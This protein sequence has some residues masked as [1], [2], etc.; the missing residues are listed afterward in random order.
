[1]LNAIIQFIRNFLCCI[2]DTSYGEAKN[3]V[4]SWL[5]DASLTNHWILALFQIKLVE[6]LHLTTPLE[7]L[8]SITQFYVVCTG[9]P[10]AINSYIQSYKQMNRIYRLIQSRQTAV[11][12]THGERLVHA[13]LI[14]E[15][16]MSIRSMIVA[17]NCFF[18]SASFVWLSANSWHIT[19]TDWIG[20][21]PALIQA[22]LIMNICLT[23]L[24]YYMYTDSIEYFQKALRIRLL[25]VKL[26]AGS[27]T[28]ADIG[29]TSLQALSETGWTPFWSTR[30]SGPNIKS[31]GLDDDIQLLTKEIVTVQTMIDDITG[32]TAIQKK[33]DDADAVQVMRAQIQK[34]AAVTMETMI[35]VHRRCGYRE[36][37]YLIL[38]TVA[39]YGYG[40]CIVVY[41]FPK[42]LGQ[43]DWLRLLLFHLENEDSDWYGNFAGDLMWTIEPAI[44]LLSPV[45]IR[46][47]T[48]KTPKAKT[49]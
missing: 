40:M 3:H 41:Y 21:L 33:V 4:L 11:V 13:S 34:A 22:L 9:V 35:S 23:P 32:T 36:F 2:K 27:V 38:N 37:I 42:V 18:I 39:W 1:M 12:T 25:C 16:N 44:I 8:I 5:Y 47:R 28:E 14:Q 31:K 43:P 15:A 24:L 48:P 20:G 30:Y 46:R 10:D 19:K 7:V 6:P 17:F 49:D 29:L 45:W 26:R